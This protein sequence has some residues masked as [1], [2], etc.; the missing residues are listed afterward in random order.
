MEKANSGVAQTTGDLL[1]DGMKN[2]LRYKI[3]G[4][5][6]KALANVAC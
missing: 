4:L 3:K 1:F 6:L 5:G 2:G